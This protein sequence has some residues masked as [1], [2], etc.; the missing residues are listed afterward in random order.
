MKLLL[1]IGIILVLFSLSAIRFKQED[2]YTLDAMRKGIF[3]PRFYIWMWSMVAL[4]IICIIS[5]AIWWAVS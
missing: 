5:S 4:G 3:I 1:V 2:R